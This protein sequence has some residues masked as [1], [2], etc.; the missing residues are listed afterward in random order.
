MKT[1]SSLF[2]RYMHIHCW[3]AYSLLQEV[4]KNFFNLIDCVGI[5]ALLKYRWSFVDNSHVRAWAIAIG[6]VLVVEWCYIGYE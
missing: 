5:F 6:T 1:V 2:K 3:F 4:N